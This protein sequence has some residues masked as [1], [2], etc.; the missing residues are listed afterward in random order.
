MKQLSKRAPCW[1]RPWG[2]VWRG[3]CPVKTI[4]ALLVTVL[5]ASASR[6][7]AAQG[8][9]DG[10][11]DLPPSLGAPSHEGNS[12]DFHPNADSDGTLLPVPEAIE[13]GDSDEGFSSSILGEPMQMLSD[14]PSYFESSGTWL[15]RGYW[16]TEVDYVMLNRGWDRK[17]L[18]LASEEAT[19]NSNPIGVPYVVSNVLQVRGESPGGEGLGR[20]KLGRFL[21]RDL[22]NR[23]HSLEGSWYGGGGFRQAV[24][25]EAA[26]TAGLQVS[27]F[28]DRVNPSFD[29]SSAMAYQYNS[30]MNSGEL[31]YVVRQRMHRDQMLLQPN[32]QWVRAA[33]PSRTFSFLAGARYVNVSEVLNWQATDNDS[34]AAVNEGGAYHV[35][36]DNDLFG[37]QLGASLSHETSR[38]SVTGAV[39]GGAFFNRMSLDSQFEL[40]RTADQPDGVTD[41][42]A[43][44]ISF[45][46]EFQ[47]L[48]KWHLRPNISL[49]AG[50]EVLFIDSIAL[51]PHQIN[52]IPG[53]YSAIAN[54]GDSVFMG[55]SL[56]VESYW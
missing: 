51:A 26:T 44:D 6:E 12:I 40:N 1:S 39:K 7:A 14:C 25:L 21:F 10:T 41:S 30:Q 43:D 11:G 48:G 28:L 19:R 17:G 31:N 54:S 42:T 29:G 45:V 24:S 2:I 47:L 20:V 49:R 15:R 32:G 50:F 8:V 38:W 22:S 36:T 35:E 16:Y 23:D 53:G 13:P 5:L 56:G 18:V 52:F 37:T 4:S 46:G 9:L 27:N 34:T 33:T 3:E 55:S